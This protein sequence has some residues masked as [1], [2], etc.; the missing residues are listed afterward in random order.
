M[1]QVFFDFQEDR[2]TTSNWESLYDTSLKKMQSPNWE[3]DGS[4]HLRAGSGLFSPMILMIHSRALTRQ[5]MS[6]VF[7]R[8]ILCFTWRSCCPRAIATGHEQQS[9]RCGSTE[10]CNWKAVA[11]FKKNGVVACAI[12]LPPDFV[13]AAVSVATADP[14]VGKVFSGRELT[15]AVVGDAEPV[16]VLDT[17][18][19]LRGVPSSVR[20]DDC[21]NR[22]VY[23]RWGVS[24]AGLFDSRVSC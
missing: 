22:R 7:E 24:G 10:R 1:C 17:C 2:I 8:M 11:H 16:C 18:R 14:I 3:Q 20:S 19:I 23:E 5:S 21:V 4:G 12:S 13:P 6:H 9:N 15:S